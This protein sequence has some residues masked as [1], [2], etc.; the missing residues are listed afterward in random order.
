MLP[1]IVEEVPSNYIK[2]IPKGENVYYCH[3]R[4]Y[5]HIPVFGSIGDKKKANEVCRLMNRDCGGR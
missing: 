1:Y 3:Q 5:P 4:G 2:N